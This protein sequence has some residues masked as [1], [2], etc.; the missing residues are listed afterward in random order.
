MKGISPLIAAVFLVIITV[1]A[2]IFLS[3]WLSTTSTLQ[4]G[5][6]R[7]NTLTQLQCQYADIF[8]KNATYDCGLNC[9]TGTQHTTTLTVVN[10]G[11]RN[12]NID[13]LHIRNS[14]GFVT[15]LLLNETKTITVGNSLSITNTTRATCTGINNSI[16][17]IEVSSIECASTAYDSLDSGDI[18]YTSC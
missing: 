10:S 11:K 4:A 13:R 15:S 14:T 16:E 5:K 6:I 1:V 9:T 12:I 8:I 3:S 2:S 18:I 17:V 7:N